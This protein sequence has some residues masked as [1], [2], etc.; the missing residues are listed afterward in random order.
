MFL[1]KCQTINIK[2]VFVIQYIINL[3]NLY[4]VFLSFNFSQK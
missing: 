2:Y 4:I 3:M 1:F